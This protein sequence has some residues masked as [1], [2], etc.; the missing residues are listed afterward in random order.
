[1]KELK[2]QSIEDLIAG[3]SLYRPGSDGLY[4]A[5]YKRKEQPGCVLHMTVRSLERNIKADIRLYRV[6]GTGYADCT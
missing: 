3:I 4:S 2:P 5:V 1:M 6:S